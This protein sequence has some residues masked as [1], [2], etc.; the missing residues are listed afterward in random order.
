MWKLNEEEY[1]K[2][3]DKIKEWG[4]QK[5]YRNRLKDEK[6]KFRSTYKVETNKL[7]AIYLFVLLNA[8]VVYAMISMWHFADLSYLGVLITDIAAQVLI[9]AIYCL[10][11]YF[12]KKQEENLKFEKEKLS[13]L[14]NAENRLATTD[15]TETIEANDNVVVG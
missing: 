3:L 15:D 2:K 4:I 7:I 13:C 5:Q 10:K 14:L 9:Y 6:A 8:I 1:Q 12:A 11:A